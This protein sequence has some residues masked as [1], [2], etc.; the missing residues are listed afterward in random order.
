MCLHPRVI[1]ILPK[2][3]M[4]THLG[5]TTLLTSTPG[6]LPLLRTL[7]VCVESMVNQVASGPLLISPSHQP[8]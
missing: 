1:L 3:V 4:V 2:E 6:A 5:P 8:H 7:D